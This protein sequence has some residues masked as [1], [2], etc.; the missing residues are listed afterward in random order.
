MVLFKR[1]ELT[2]IIN[3]IFENIKNI[4]FSN[5]SSKKLENLAKVKDAILTG[6]LHMI[7]TSITNTYHSVIF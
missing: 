1:N 7:L 6:A 5:E 4:Q 2:T 3:K